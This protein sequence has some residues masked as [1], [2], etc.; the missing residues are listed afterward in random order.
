MNDDAPT[1][2]TAQPVQKV[3]ASSMGGPSHG[4]ENYQIGREIARGGMGSVLEAEDQKL[5][6]TVA[7]KI[8]HFDANASLAMQQRFV[9][10]AEVLALLAHPNIVPIYDIVWDRGQPLFYSMKMVKGR[11]LQAI[12]N[13]LRSGHPEALGEYTLDRLLLIF[14]KVCDAMAFAHSKGVLHRDLK[15]ENI[16]VGEFGEVLVMDW[17]LAKS[18]SQGDPQMGRP[19]EEDDLSLSTH[20]MT[21]L[22]LQT[23][24]GDVMGTPQYMSPEQA[25]GQI[26]ELDERSDIFSLGGIL[27][28][29]L[30]LRPP[31]E[32]ATLDEVLEKVRTAQITAPSAIQGGKKE[33]GATGQKADVLAANLIRPLPHVS[34]GRVP[35]ALSAVVMQALRRSKSERYQTVEAFSA[36]I[37]AYQGGFA[38]SAEQAGTWKQLKLLMLRH[39]IVTG[40]LAALLVISTL[41]LIKVM[42]SERAARASEAVAIE[43]EGETRQA[44][45]RAAISL[46]EAALREGDGPATRRALDEVPADLRGPT[47]HYLIQQS[48]SSISRLGMISAACPHPRRPG[49]FAVVNFKEGFRLLNV[50]T[51]KTL[52]KFDSEP[53]SKDWGYTQCIAM[54]P[55]AERIAVLRRGK[56]ANWIQVYQVKSGALISQS[57]TGITEKLAFSPDG[58]RLVSAQHIYKSPNLIHLWDVET[59]A[60]IWTHEIG[61]VV[62]EAV[63]TPDGQQILSLARGAPPELINVTDGTLMSR[64]TPHLSTACA[65]RPDGALIA[66]GDELG[67]I[68]G[69]D[70]KNGQVVF[71]VRSSVSKITN[72]AFTSDGRR[73]ISISILKDGR[74]DIRLWDAQTGIPVQPLLGGQGDAHRVTVHPLSGEMLVEG[75]DARAWSLG[76]ERWLMSN[77]ASRACLA[78]WGSDDLLFA[79][80]EKSSAMLLR[81]S[82]DPPRPIEIEPAVTQG[83]AAISADGRIAAVGED[84]GSS[85]LTMLQKTGDKSVQIGRLVPR[86]SHA[87]PRVSPT[88]KHVAMA[89]YRQE[90]MVVMETATGKELMFLEKDFNHYADF[91]W[92]SENHLLG[93]ATSKARRGLKASEQKLVVWDVTKKKVLKSAT[94]KTVL[95][96][97]VLAPDGKTFA[98]AGPDKAVH[99]YDAETLA[100]LREF[101]AHEGA[102]TALAW[103]PTQPILA[104]GSEDLTL[105]LWDI[106]TGQRI[107]E[108]RGPLATLHTLAFSP[109]GNRLGCASLDGTTRIWEMDFAQ[110]SGVG[111]P[112]PAVK[113]G[114]TGVN[115]RNR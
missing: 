14:R 83:F 60:K 30:T 59:G 15:P 31:V 67:M 62:L 32:G 88:G 90:Q 52:R 1:I 40:A 29:I 18:M 70:L 46:A 105:R 63:F 6:R 22:S 19:G 57:K 80:G 35:P 93:L 54:S 85:P 39:K 71:Q 28:A 100:E 56:D 109:S 16:M 114:E 112:L 26:D 69:T 36:D 104:T 11:T 12:L 66:T 3:P 2:I 108:L 21:S 115:P 95:D 20:L 77:T 110:L 98:A 75:T 76:G 4:A 25:M 84:F 106:K 91:I 42:A 58:R 78:F 8:M 65:I 45:A 47:W 72:L 68:R 73:L 43:R 97:I 89:I 50:R 103:H 34:G 99:F 38:T 102:I 5:K 17:G 51:Q 74:Q 24:Q 79:P 87:L 9:R 61:Q 92:L 55:D 107:A 49:V 113:A 27:Y 7:V 94:S 33:K 48:D 111:S 41:F 23:M 86:L 81:L 101:R 37:E 13:D 10:E 96:V 44:L 64:P 53:A 82:E